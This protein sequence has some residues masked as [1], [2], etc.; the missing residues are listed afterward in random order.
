MRTSFSIL[1]RLISVRLSSAT[2]WSRL[3]WIASPDI[4]GLR[5]DCVST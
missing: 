1:G 4:S 2:F 5:I 3:G